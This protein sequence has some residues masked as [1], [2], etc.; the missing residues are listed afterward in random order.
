MTVLL[1][2]KAIL[3]VPSEP[4]DPAPVTAEIHIDNWLDILPYV[5]SL[6]L[7]KFVDPSDM[8]GFL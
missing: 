8:Y 4:V 1:G 7:Y 3:L 6:L 2:L 5:E